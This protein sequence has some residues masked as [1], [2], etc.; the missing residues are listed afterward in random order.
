MTYI[1]TFA[2]GVA[3]GFYGRGKIPD[4]EDVLDK[5]MRKLLGKD[6]KG[7]KK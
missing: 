3:L 4:K 1:V 2:V 6:K 7:G 5:V